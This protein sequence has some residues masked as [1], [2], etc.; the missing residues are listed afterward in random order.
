M[1]YQNINQYNFKKWYLTPIYESY[2]M[3]LASDEKNF[4]EEAVFSNEVMYM[5]DGNKL[6]I[7]IDLNFSA[8]SQ[9]LTLNYNTY[10]YDNVVVSSNFYNP[11]NDDITILTSTTICDVG[12]TAIDNGLVT[13]MTG[14]TISATTSIFNSETFNR[15]FFDR[16][17]KMFQVTGNTSTPNHRFSATTAETLYEMVSYSGSSEGYYVELYGGYY[18][19]FYE[20]FGYDY[21]TFPERVNKGWSVEMV[22]KPRLQDLF[23]GTTGQ[24]TLNQVYPNNEN[25][26]FYFGTRAE[27]KFY[28]FANGNPSSDSGYTRV[29]ENLVDCLKTCACSDTGVTNSRCIEVYPSTGTT[30]IHTE[31]CECGCVLTNKTI[32]TSETDPLYDSLS[33]ALAFKLCGNPENPQ[34]GIRVL[35]FTGDCIV[36]GVTPNTGITYQTGYTVTDYCSDKGIY[37]YCSGTTYSN[38]EHWFLIDVVWDRYTWFDTCDLYYRGGLGTIT[39]FVYLDSLSNNSV[40]L[41]SPDITHYGDDPTQIEIVDINERWLYEKDYRKGKLKIY[42]N[43]RL[44]YTINNFEEI[45]PRSLNTEKERQVG[46][47]FNISWGGG[48]FGLREN[49]TFSG[50]P[51]GLTN[52]YIQDPECLPNSTLSGSSLSSLTTNIM[53]EDHFGGTFE[54]AISQFRFYIT[55]LNASEIRHNFDVLKNKFLMFDPDCPSC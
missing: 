26:F 3:C 9:F 40:A 42:I 6:P 36:T 1:S 30:T 14:E 35:S 51:T 15:Y 29:T 55:P 38:S 37:D 7:N 18:Q 46:V 31:D 43:G 54:G 39:K 49:L 44:F 25:I 48:S 34:I 47:P 22:L 53:I 20:L 16:R 45:I 32:P 19:G 4:N 12:L 24:T 27:N 23:S 28:H 13:E 10:D 5:G 17:F 11:N 33:N 50:C 41:I 21:N 52:T 2:D 8:C